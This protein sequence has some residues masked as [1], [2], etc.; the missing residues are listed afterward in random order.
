MCRR[1]TNPETHGVDPVPL[2]T[3]RVAVVRTTVMP[4]FVSAVARRAMPVVVDLGAAVGP[5][6]EFLSERLDCTV[7]VQDFGRRHVARLI[8][9]VD[10]P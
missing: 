1:A 8:S 9:V 10:K 7:H 3:D 6:V 2:N 4:K 5:N